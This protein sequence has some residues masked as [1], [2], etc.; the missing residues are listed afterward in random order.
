LDGP[1]VF[2]YL[3]G[4]VTNDVS[5]LE[6]EPPETKVPTPTP[7]MGSVTVPP[8]YTAI[9]NPQGRFLYD[10]FLYRPA[11]P[12]ERLDKTGSGPKAD[13]DKSPYLLADV[14]SAVADELVSHLNR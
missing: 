14:D 12:V 11:H 5:R 9:L 7:T 10:L 4:L 6:R 2:K 3:Q 8:L 1:D 13:E